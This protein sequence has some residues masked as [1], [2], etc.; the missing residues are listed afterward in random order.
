[1]QA[2]EGLSIFRAKSHESRGRGRFDERLRVRHPK[3]LRRTDS[4]D[5]F[6]CSKGCHVLGSDGLVPRRPKVFSPVVL[7][8]AV[9]KQ[10]R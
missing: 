1:M 2:L 7:I 9:L 4:R 8:E 5:L 3:L 6:P 10:Q